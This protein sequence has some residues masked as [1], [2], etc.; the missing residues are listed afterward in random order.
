MNKE[1]IKAYNVTDIVWNHPENMSV[2]VTE[3]LVNIT[4]DDNKWGWDAMYDNIKTKLET[5]FN[6]KIEEFELWDVIDGD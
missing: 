6:G 2:V 4:K 5:T 3:C 1:I